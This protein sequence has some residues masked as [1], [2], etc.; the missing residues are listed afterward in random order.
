M[1]CE[2]F[3]PDPRCGFVRFFSAEGVLG[4]R[5]KGFEGLGLLRVSWLGVNRVWEFSSR[6]MGFGLEGSGIQGSGASGAQA[7]FEP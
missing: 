7:N 3:V 5:D 2:G 1:G 4:L 6:L